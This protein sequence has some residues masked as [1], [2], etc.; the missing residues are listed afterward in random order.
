MPIK[1]EFDFDD[2]D[3]TALLIL[4]DCTTAQLPSRLSAHAKAALHEYVECYM[5]RRAYSRGSDILEHRLSLLIQHV[6]GD[7]M[8]EAA[9]VSDFFQTNLTTS[10][11][12]IRNTFAKFRYDLEQAAEASARIALETVTW[13]GDDARATFSTP[14]LL[15]TLNR[16]LLK[17]DP[18]ANEVQRM[19]NVI[20][21]YTIPEFS[22]ATL[23]TAFGANPVAKP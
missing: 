21:V 5:G 19:A 22:Y 2:K 14:N 23:C 3:S 8:P 13:S 1:I 11:S 20:G 7:R 10:R 6:L 4:L 9:Q 16:R 18:T 12:L 17:V 15:E